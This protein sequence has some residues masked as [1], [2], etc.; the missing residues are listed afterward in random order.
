LPLDRQK[1]SRT[2]LL[3]LL[4][5]SMA[6]VGFVAA[7]LAVP[8]FLAVVLAVFLAPLQLRMSQRLRGRRGLAAA[9]LVVGVLLILVVPL[10]SLSTVIVTEG[11]DGARFVLDTVR[12]EGV[13][14]LLGH[15]PGP[16]Q[17]LADRVLG[18][19]GDLDELVQ[20]GLAQQGS[21]AASAVGA[22]MSATGGVLF[23][24]AMMLIALFFLLVQGEAL[25]AWIDQA[26]P[27]KPG[28]TRELFLEFKN[29]SYAVIVSTVV[30]A[31]VQ[32]AAALVGYL[33]ARVPH[34]MFFAGV[35]FFFAL[36]PAIGAATVCLFAAALLVLTGHLYMAAF[37]A[38]WGFAVVGLVD[39]VVKPY[40]IRG[41]VEM[42]G[43]VV[44]FALIGGIG[45]FGMIGVLVGPLAVALFLALLRMYQ[46]DYLQR[47]PR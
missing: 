28:R 37:L 33:I 17:G 46:R 9:I 16:L 12:S 15:L 38:V 35:T 44:F 40:L 30:T 45:A 1:T 27:L 8:L 5:A 2:A 21:K 34:P 39:N 19:I 14:G 41:G 24:L 32:S 23:D 3:V 47:E 13:S 36:V 25:L 4:L 10:A 11:I 18:Y 22:A 31:A 7:P 42:A 6:L 20:R 26:S 43:A 29:V